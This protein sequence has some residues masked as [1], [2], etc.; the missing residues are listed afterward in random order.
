MYRR[1][2]SNHKSFTLI[3]LLVVVAI[4]AVLAAILLPALVR[5]REA[6]RKAVCRSN[7][8]QMGIGWN[9]Y[10]ED[11]A[12][13]GPYNHRD[14][15]SEGYG[16]NLCVWA[17]W[18]MYTQ[19]GLLFPYVGVP[20]RGRHP[21][22]IQTPGVVICPAD[23]YGRST[24]NEFAYQDWSQ[25]SYW[26]NWEACSYPGNNVKPVVVD[27]FAWWQPCRWDEN[28]WLGNHGREGTTVLRIDGSVIWIGAD[29]TRGT[30]PYDF[31]TLEKF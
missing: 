29:A 25:T 4:I 27:A 31:A 24:P 23:A 15:F 13:L 11:N 5:A 1:I 26:M 9:M 21:R 22:E 28:I 14:H 6:A 16:G 30:Y 3:E 10:A 17:Y 19:F 8:R 7:Q 12:D 20:T 18:E 2:S